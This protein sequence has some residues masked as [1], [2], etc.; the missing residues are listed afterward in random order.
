MRALVLIGNGWG[1]NLTAEDESPGILA[2]LESF[3]WELTVVSPVAS[4][5][6]CGYAA[7]TPA[8]ARVR[9]QASPGDIADVS[10]YDALVVAPGKDFDSLVADEGVLSLA[11]RASG[12]GLAVASFCRGVRVLAAAGV[13]AGR[14]VTGPAE[15][16]A[17]CAAAGARFLGYADR[18]G[19]QDA[20]PP[21]VDGFLVT[22]L[23][24][25][26]YRGAACEALRVAAENAR[27]VRRARASGGV[28]AWAERPAR[29]ALFAFM[30]TPDAAREALLLSGSLRRFGGAMSGSRLLCMVPGDTG[31]VDPA[32]RARLEALGCELAGFEPEPRLERW[33][34]AAKAGAAAA[35]EAL[36][37]G[38]ADVLVWMDSDTVIVREPVELLLGE[39]V[40]AAASP[41]HH[42]LIG[43]PWGQAPDAFWKAVYAAAGVDPASAFPMLTVADR[44]PIAA[45]LNAGLLA[46]RPEAGLLAAWRDAFLAASDAPAVLEA[47]RGAS[48]PH[49]T[50]LH[51]AALAAAAIGTVGPGGLAALSYGYNYPIH[52]HGSCPPG[53][54]PGK[55]DDLYTAR[56]DRWALAP[57]GPSDAL[58]APARLRSALEELRRD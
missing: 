16:E 48:G 12:A 4:P 14:T 35:A 51:Q 30:L 54:R 3:G 8:A 10:A 41:V 28:P 21:V 38:R 42:R 13:I 50:F 36:S 40:S 24:G 9:V 18:A 1:A 20:P 45:Y 34:L 2:R 32:L 56:Y 26:Y 55:L 33:P 17:E 39:G 6:P 19:K 44:E 31:S 43:M 23:R 58:P 25:R 47:I 49:R 15:L 29:T 7:G 53:L 22:S 46:A 52:M 57:G 11:R 37:R 27:R 5:R